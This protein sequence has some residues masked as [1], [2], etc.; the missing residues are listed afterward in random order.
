MANPLE[1]LR[2]HVSGAIARGE[3]VAIAGIPS[4]E[5]ATISRDNAYRAW[6]A[7]DKA[8]QAELVRC[9]GRNAGD[10]R[11]QAAGVATDALKA[12]HSAF[13]DAG[14]VYRAAQADYMAAK[15]AA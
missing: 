9:Y 4:I 13:R 2:H 15:G 11:Y 6:V 14:N 12:L 3:A 8:W 1:R 7:A 10:M 5:S